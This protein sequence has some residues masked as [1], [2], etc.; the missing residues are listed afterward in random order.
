MNSFIDPLAAAAQKYHLQKGNLETEE[1]WKTRLVYSICGMMAYT[2][3]WDDA[4]EEPISLVHLKSRVGKILAGYKSIYPEL[5]NH[6]KFFESPLDGFAKLEDE[7]VAQFVNAGI[8]YHGPYRIAP[9]MKHE[10]LCSGILFQ[11]G[12]SSD[13]ISRISGLGFY[14]KQD[15]MGNPDTVKAM[16]GLEQMR[17]PGVW[18]AALDSANWK[19]SL[20]FA[21]SMEY[22]RLKPP[23]TKGYW[24]SCP[25]SNGTVSLLRTGE[26]G[27]RLYWL[28]RYFGSSLETCPLP[29]WQVESGN[30]RRLACACLSV[31]GTLPPIEYFDDGALIHVKMQYLPPPR[32]LDFL[33]L[34]SWPEPCT[35]L[36]CSFNRVLTREVFTAVKLILSDTGYTFKEVFAGAQR[37]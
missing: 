13:A 17:L 30:Y 7:I 4:E 18:Q 37:S 27:S 19:Q 28:Y 9:A 35:S 34:F 26:K 11:R 15:G 24:N 33:K 8:V 29:Q 25:I 10:A 23:F 2:S 6:L 32:E 3:L 5:S 21:S 14:S 22:L 36:P 20:S 31:Y 16:F 1:S 12:I